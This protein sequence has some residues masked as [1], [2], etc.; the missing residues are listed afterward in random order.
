MNQSL[1]QSTL[2]QLRAPAPA[3]HAPPGV[4]GTEQQAP[5]QDCENVMKLLQA[6]SKI[7]RGVG[8]GKLREMCGEMDIEGTPA[9]EFATAVYEAN[10]DQGI[11]GA[12]RD[13]LVAAS[14]SHQKRKR[15]KP[16]V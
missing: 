13:M 12:L 1:L 7:I 4:V 8:L 9:P 2:D 16:S 10:G 11:L 14:E 15:A 6:P 5:S 3:M